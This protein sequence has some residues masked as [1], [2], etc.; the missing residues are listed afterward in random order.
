LPASD[1]F[2]LQFK[3]CSFSDTV[4]LQSFL[5]QKLSFDVSYVICLLNDMI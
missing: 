2:P 1:T 5:P 3:I 4:G